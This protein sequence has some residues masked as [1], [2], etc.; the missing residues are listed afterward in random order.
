VTNK[1][2]EAPGARRQSRACT[3]DLFDTANGDHR[4]N[5]G[6]ALSL[7]R[8]DHRLIAV[9]DHMHLQRVFPIV[10]LCVSLAVAAAAARAQ[11]PAQPQGNTYTLI[12]TPEQGTAENAPGTATGRAGTLQFI[13]TATVLIRFQGFTI[14]TDPNFLHK[15]DRVRLGFGNTAARLTNPAIDL[16]QLPPID[17]VILSSIQEDHFDKLVQEKLS[18]DTPIATTRQAADKLKQLGFVRTA[19]LA[20][21]DSLEVQKGEARLRVTSV[22]GRHGRGANAMQSK[23]MGSVLDFGNKPGTP[24]YRIYIS[25]DTV[26]YNEMPTIAQRFP[27]VDLALLHLGGARFM[28]MFKVSMDG[29]DGV[30]MLQIIQPSKAIPIHYDDYDVFKSPLADFTRAT[31]DAGL[32]QKVVSL[33]PGETYSFTPAKR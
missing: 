23:V 19:A 1:K 24:D 30:E 15:G 28:G 20:T 9:E 18:K 17:L 22:P 16:A 7:D 29:K 13:G 21:W 25:G 6:V 27:G 26:I 3:I 4:Q 8:A 14:L 32:E 12:L 10:A 33:A 5:D 11:A 2:R 31:K